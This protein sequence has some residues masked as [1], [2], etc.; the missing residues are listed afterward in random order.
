MQQEKPGLTLDQVDVNACLIEK[1]EWSGRNALCSTN[2]FFGFICLLSSPIYVLLQGTVPRIL[3]HEKLQQA[4]LEEIPGTRYQEWPEV[5]DLPNLST[6][7]DRR[8]FRW[9]PKTALL[10]LLL[11]CSREY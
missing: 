11:F 8:L 9:E 2:T 5:S 4:H 10:S 6:A 3:P 1:E 7:L